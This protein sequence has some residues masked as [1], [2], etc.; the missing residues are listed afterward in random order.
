M[1]TSR[2]DPAELLPDEP[3]VQLSDWFLGAVEYSVNPR[4][5]WEDKLKIVYNR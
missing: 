1:L 3:I 2:T 5:D 4:L